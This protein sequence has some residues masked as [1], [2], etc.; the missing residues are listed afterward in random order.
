ML[1]ILGNIYLTG[2]RWFFRS[3]R[4]NIVRYQGYTLSEAL[5][6]EIMATMMFRLFV[7]FAE[8]RNR[9]RDALLDS[10]PVFTLKDCALL[11]TVSF[12]IFKGR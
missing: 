1:R 11:L 5:I 4:K 6:N 3:L 10:V 2:H 7:N 8:T 12:K 9:K